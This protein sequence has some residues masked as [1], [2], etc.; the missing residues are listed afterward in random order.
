MTRRKTLTDNMVAKLKPGPKRMTLPDPEL[1][2]HYV[3]ITPTGA[4]SFVAGR[5]IGIRAAAGAAR[6]HQRRRRELSLTARQGERAALR[7]RDRA[8]F[9]VPS[10]SDLE[11]PRVGQHPAR[12]RDCAAGSDTGRQ[13]SQRRRSR[14]RRRASGL[15]LAR[16]PHR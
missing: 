16:R 11:G 15:F 5:S 10:L 7:G 4:K 8:H 1:R 13:R 6:L 14:A 9:G 2:G 12:R 3:R